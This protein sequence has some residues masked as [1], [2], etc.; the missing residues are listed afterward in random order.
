MLGSFLTGACAVRV[1]SLRSFALSRC[2]AIGSGAVHGRARVTAKRRSRRSGDPLEGPAGTA[3]APRTRRRWPAAG[4]RRRR[5]RSGS[6]WGGTTPSGWRFKKPPRS[7]LLFDLDTGRVLYRREPT[8]VVPIA[9]LTKLMTALVVAERDPAGRQ[10][11]HHKGGAALPGLGR[12]AAAAREVDR[13]EHDAATACC[14]PRAMTRR[15]RSPSAPPAA[16]SRRFVRYM[17]EKAEEIGAAVHAVRPPSGIEDQSNHSCAADLAAPARA[18]LREPRLKRI[19]GRARRSCR[20]RSRAA[21]STSTTTTRC[22]ASAIAAP[23]GMKTGY[24]DA[25]G[26]C[27]VATAR[28]GPVKLG[29]VL[30][31]L[32]RPRQAGDAAARPGLPGLRRDMNG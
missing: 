3:A 14:C 24:T 11:P 25:A 12:R 32:A 26:R 30:L 16:A 18:V 17:N 13:R 7:A 1:A 27:L 29:V 2:V 19:V 5:S 21:A 20:S 22:C 10:G 9:S 23:P 4:P 28:R 8:K 31:R 6:T 15:S